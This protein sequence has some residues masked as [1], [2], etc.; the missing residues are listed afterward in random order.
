MDIQ[1]ATS[2]AVV[3]AQ[4]F[5][6][7]ITGQHWLIENKIVL[8]EEFQ[9]GAVF[10]DMFVQIPTR[11]FQLQVIPENC[12]LIVL[13]NLDPD[14]QQKLIKERLGKI[15]STLPH[16]PYT[17][18]GLNFVWHF[19]P[20][21][22]TISEA[23]RRLFFSGEKL[24]HKEFNKGDARFGGYMSMDWRGFR[25]KL[26]AKPVIQGLPDGQQN[27]LIQFAFNYHLAVAGRPKPWSE[28]I[29]TLD[30]WSLARSNSLSIVNTATGIQHE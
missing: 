24:L 25:L 26:D 6:P 18:V 2:S 13:P 29:D 8:P 20:S 15:I 12:Q 10:T 21:N 11:D 7:S 27:E 9:V 1:L 30:Q 23:C 19:F 4:H 16:T 17:A 3:A 22:E 28:I 5:N 14:K